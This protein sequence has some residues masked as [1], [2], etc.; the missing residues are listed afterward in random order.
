M[1]A[2]KVYGGLGEHIT[3]LRG[4]RNMGSSALQTS[5]PD[6]MRNSPVPGFTHPKSG[7]C[8]AATSNALMLS[9]AA[10]V[11]AISKH[12][13]ATFLLSS[14]LKR[15]EM[16]HASV[17]SVKSGARLHR[18]PRHAHGRCGLMAIVRQHYATRRPKVLASDGKGSL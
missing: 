13:L 14:L 16:C 18:D 8:C 4:E 12:L 7:C 6:R 15:Q 5:L 17:F 1:H 3:Q 9:A 10:S 11:P 2:Q